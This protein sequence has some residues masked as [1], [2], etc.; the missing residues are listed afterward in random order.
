MTQAIMGHNE[1][2]LQYFLVQYAFILQRTCIYSQ[3]YYA[4]MRRRW[5]YIYLT[6]TAHCYVPTCFRKLNF[7]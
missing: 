4:C 5:T 6:Y 3:L 1:P 2:N 7:S